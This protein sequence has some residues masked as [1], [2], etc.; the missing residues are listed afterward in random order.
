MK[1]IAHIVFIIQFII[2]HQF[3]YSAEIEIG[4]EKINSVCQKHIQFKQLV[5]ESKSIRSIELNEKKL[6]CFH[7]KFSKKN[8]ISIKRNIQKFFP[9]LNPKVIA[10][11]G[12][13]IGSIGL[14]I[15]GMPLGL[16]GFLLSSWALN[17]MKKKK[18]E[19]GKGYAIAGMIVGLVSLF[20]A[21]VVTFFEI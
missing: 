8:N 17:M 15:F 2:F 21:F 18:N 4:K 5:D 3:A 14:F 20:G 7:A 1:R 6:F 9:D 11:I 13:V 19:T 12:L 16:A 10:I